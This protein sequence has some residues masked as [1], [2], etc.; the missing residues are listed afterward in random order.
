MAPLHGTNSAAHIELHQV[1]SAAALVAAIR[2]LPLPAG[3]GY[4]WCAGEASAMARVRDV[5]LGEK[6][7]PREA[8]RIA[9]YWK[10]GSSDYHDE[11]G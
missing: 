8:M 7:H 10:Q 9:A 2:A 5:V 6:A 1:T 11:L 3:E 4:V